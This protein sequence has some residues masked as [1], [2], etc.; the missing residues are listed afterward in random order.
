MATPLAFLSEIGR[1]IDPLTDIVGICQQVSSLI[2][3]ALQLPDNVIYLQNPEQRLQQVAAAGAKF[4]Q[5]QGVLEPL[6]LELGQGV[7][8]TAALKQSSLCIAD[9]AS[10][11]HYVVDDAPRLSELSVPLTYQGELLGVI[12]AEHPQA[13]FFSSE[14]QYFVEVVAAML[15]P[16]LADLSAKAKMQWRFMP[17]SAKVNHSQSLNTGWC[18]QSQFMEL[19]QQLLKHFYQ[20][21]NWQSSLLQSSALFQQHRCAR[22]QNFTALQTVQAEN[23][24]QQ[25]SHLLTQMQQKEATA[26]WAAI[27]SDRY[28][29]K[30]QGQL[31][32]ADKYHMGFSTFRRYQAQAVAYLGE[33]LWQLELQAR[34]H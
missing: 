5:T 24:R 20:P 6:Q 28:I 33:Q 34:H 29:D 16:R 12:D 13:G 14:H 27:I 18:S 7:V 26:L 9:T 11:G 19:V 21:A 1:R 25:L 8:G 32:L 31:Q 17:R 15:A 3:Q 4:C 22:H 23:I 30:R 2:V 10:F